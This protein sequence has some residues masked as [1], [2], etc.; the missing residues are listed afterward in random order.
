M[1]DLISR[2]ISILALSIAISLGC[3]SGFA[4]QLFDDAES[5]GV[6]SSCFEDSLGSNLFEETDE[7][8]LVGSL[9]GTKRSVKQPTK[10]TLRA[11]KVTRS[12]SLRQSEK[13]IAE[14]KEN[15]VKT[16]KLK[17]VPVGRVQSS[18]VKNIGENRKKVALNRLRKD[19]GI[20]K[21]KI[22][23]PEDPITLGFTDS[24]KDNRKR[25]KAAPVKKSKVSVKENQKDTKQQKLVAQKEYGN[26]EVFSE[27]YLNGPGEKKSLNIS[28]NK[29]LI[30]VTEERD[31]LLKER[32]KL[33]AL[34]KDQQDYIDEQA[35]IYEKA[36]AKTENKPLIVEYE[37]SRSKAVKDV[38]MPDPLV[39]ETATVRD[40]KEEVSSIM[41]NGYTYK[42]TE[43]VSKI[44]NEPTL[45][46][47]SEYQLLDYVNGMM[48]TIYTKVGYT[49]VVI[50]PAGEKLER[51]TIGDRQRFNVSTVFDKSS[52][53]WHIYL[54]PVQ[55]NVTTNMV[56]ATDR[57]LFNATLGTSEF[58]KPF[59]KWINVPGAVES[60]AVQDGALDLAV[61]DVDALNFKYK[62][63]GDTDSSWTPLNIFDDKNGHTFI[64]FDGKALVKYHPVVLTKDIT[65]DVKLVPYSRYKN[66]FIIDNIYGNLEVRV[67]DK[68]VVYVRKN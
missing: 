26:P 42:D 29:E 21:R 11:T 33:V 7:D 10:K 13:T 27:E 41:G 25:L 38:P 15:P 48:N 40:Y 61:K 9:D 32:E 39:E 52:G 46:E 66:T 63:S 20:S 5:R 65:G 37:G 28:K 18:A 31:K 49:T 8:I 45:R 55:M 43:S 59:V 67:N 3:N 24:N 6:N 4:N 53:S 34:I 64:S 56:I 12:Q 14:K 16:V 2:R 47:Q 30:S 50:L 1:N 62:C 58:F 19:D 36:K 22:V 44:T 60:V 35:E 68:S 57:H 17:A 51:V 54:Q 23:L